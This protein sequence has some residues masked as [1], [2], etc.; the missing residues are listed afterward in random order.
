MSIDYKLESL[1]H[2]NEFAEMYHKSFSLSKTGPFKSIDELLRLADIRS[3]KRIL[4]IATGSGAVAREVAKISKNVVAIDLA[5]NMLR[6][7]DRLAKEDRLDI[8]LAEMDGEHLG[9]RE[10]T[11]DLVLCQFGLMLFPDHKN[12]LRDIARVLKPRG[13]FICSVHGSMDN[14][15]YFRII[16]RSIIKNKPDAF[17]KDR[18]NPTRFG[19]TNLFLKELRAYFDDVKIHRYNYVYRVSSFEEYWHDFLNSITSKMKDR[20]KDHLTDI[21]EDARELSKDYIDDGLKFPWEVII[22]EAS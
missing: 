1:I 6:I 8:M 22:A 2:W 17:P 15:P 18:P 11:F 12:A 21:K 4:D 5:I 19:D 14:V 10:Q 13:K 20:L 9:F 16:S 3:D 7:I